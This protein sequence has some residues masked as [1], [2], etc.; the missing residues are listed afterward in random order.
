MSGCRTLLPSGVEQDTGQWH[1][2][3][4]VEETFNLIE[5]NSTTIADMSALGIDFR[6]TPNITK[7]TYLDVMERFKLDSTI[8]NGVALPPGI[9]S[10]LNNHDRCIAYEIIINN[11]RKTR[12]GGFWKDLLGFEQIT[13]TTG[14]SFNALV[15]IDGDVVVYVLHSGKPK[16]ERTVRNKKPL[17]PF[18]SIDGV[19]ILDAID[20]L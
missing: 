11:T 17:G 2:Y 1:A 10:A 9:E 12:T 4:Q 13:K 15:V 19:Q 18:Q 7:L 20:G 8:F 16:I 5:S 6:T 14:W 3:A